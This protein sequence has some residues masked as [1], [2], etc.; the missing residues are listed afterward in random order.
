M[1]PH[2]IVNAIRTKWPEASGVY[3]TD[4]FNK[5]LKTK[6]PAST[7]KPSKTKAVKTVKVPKIKTTTVRKEK[8]IKTPAPVPENKIK[9][10]KTSRKK[11]V[12]AKIVTPTKEQSQP[13]QY[14]ITQL[15]DESDVF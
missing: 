6:N 15:Y 5:P 13:N 11:S 7:K 4:I 10:V 8:K 9:K 14:T 3:S 1:L 12:A 2:C